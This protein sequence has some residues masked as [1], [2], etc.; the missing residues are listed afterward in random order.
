LSR[1]ADLLPPKPYTEP[2]VSQ[3]PPRIYDAEPAQRTAIDER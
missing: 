3:P 2:L 1:Y